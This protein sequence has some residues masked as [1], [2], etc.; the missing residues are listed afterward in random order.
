MPNPQPL[1]G[2]RVSNRLSPGGALSDL[3]KAQVTPIRSLPLIGAHFCLPRT[4][5]PHP[6]P[7][8]VP[9]DVPAGGP[10]SVCWAPGEMHV[11]PDNRFFFSPGSRP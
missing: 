6:A 2:F 3:S 1:A 11:G 7:A 8:G 4:P 10:R 5:E 9:G